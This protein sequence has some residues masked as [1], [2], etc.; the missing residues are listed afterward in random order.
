VCKNYRNILWF[1][2]VIA[3]RSQAV[4]VPEIPR[5]LCVIENFAKSL[6]IIRNDTVEYR[7]VLVPISISLKLRL[8]VV[9]LKTG[10]GVVQGH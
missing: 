5:A 10:V 4:A 1:D 2:K 6:D 7:R 3:T 9:L 8:Y